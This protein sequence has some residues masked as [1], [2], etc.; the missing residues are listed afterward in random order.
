MR[1][2]GRGP[3]GPGISRAPFC[4]VGVAKRDKPYIDVME[5]VFG[6]VRISTDTEPRSHAPEPT[7]RPRPWLT[8]VSMSAVE[9]HVA[10]D[11][12]DAEEEEDWADR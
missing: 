6:G 5:N 1:V 7:L 9:V 4:G 8:G 12:D 11:Y 2:T 3:A 10:D